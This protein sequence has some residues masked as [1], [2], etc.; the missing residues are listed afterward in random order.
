MHG[1]NKKD[2]KF[3][4]AVGRVLIALSFKS[5]KR[6][7]ELLR[8]NR[9]KS[10]CSEAFILPVVEEERGSQQDEVITIWMLAWFERHIDIQLGNTKISKHF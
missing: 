5:F 4:R 1:N 2:L 7:N 8:R 10:D 6:N 3:R 9:E